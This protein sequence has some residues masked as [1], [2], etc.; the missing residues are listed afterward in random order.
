MNCFVCDNKDENGK[1][2]TVVKAFPEAWKGSV[3]DVGCRTKQL[4]TSLMHLPINYC[5]FDLFPPADVTGNLEKGMP[6]QDASFDVVVALDVLEHTDNIHKSVNELF[7]VAKKYVIINLPNTYEFKCRLKFL[8]GK[9]LSGKYGLPIDA[10]TDRHRW[11]FSFNEAFNFTHAMGNRQ[12]FEVK[13]EGCLVGPNRGGFIGRVM[14]RQLP[15]LLAPWY[16][17]LL[18]RKS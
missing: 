4:K 17:A 11:L 16:L 18:E 12:N 8:A 15:D 7:R 9:N 14:T 5:G 13:K 3:L 6:F 10:P 1:L 2:S